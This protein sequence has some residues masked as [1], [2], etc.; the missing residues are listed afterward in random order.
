MEYSHL[1]RKRNKKKEAI[2]TFL[3]IVALGI[4]IIAFYLFLASQIATAKIN[5]EEMKENAVL[6]TFK[7]YNPIEILKNEL[8]SSNEDPILKNMTII[9]VITGSC[10]IVVFIIFLK[11]TSEKIK[12]I[13]QVNKNNSEKPV[14]KS[15][16]YDL[17]ILD[18][19]KR[20]NDYLDEKD[21]ENAKK[22]YKEIQS[23]YDSYLND[24]KEV[25]SKI[26]EFYKRILEN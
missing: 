8:G 13:K 11:L 17:K 18:L 9:L 22:I 5:V 21:V 7:V 19:I 23:S 3:Q 14:E 1:I 24:N 15:N 2:F 10:I 6:H 25:Y 4:F 16:D 12:K 20:G 26:L